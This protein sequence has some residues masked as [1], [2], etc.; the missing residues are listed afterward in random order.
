[1]ATCADCVHVEVCKEYEKACKL[2]WVI[3]PVVY[4]LQYF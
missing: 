2:E 3:D 1:M 4:A